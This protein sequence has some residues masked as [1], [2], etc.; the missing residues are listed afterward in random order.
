MLSK[1]ANIQDYSLLD[2]R[3]VL[4]EVVRIMLSKAKVQLLAKL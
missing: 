1:M 3:A 2:K 4:E